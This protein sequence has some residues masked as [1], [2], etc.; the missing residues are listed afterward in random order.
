MARPMTD[1]P[2]IV[3]PDSALL[4]GELPTLDAEFAASHGPIFQIA[5]PSGVPLVFMVGPE[6][7]RFVLHTHR[8]HF[9]HALGWTPVLGNWAGQGLL[10]LAPPLHT[11]HRR[12]MNPAFTSAFMTTY[13][14]IMQRVVAR[15][16][17]DWAERNEVD[18]AVETREIAFDVAAAAL[19]GLHSGGPIEQL[20][21]LF[22]GLLH[23][24]DGSR[25]TPEEFEQR[26][27]AMSAQVDNLLLPII[28]AR[29][30]DETRPRDVLG[31][32]ATARDAEDKPLSDAQ[33]LAH[34]KILLIAGHE[35]TTTLAAWALYTLATHPEYRARVDAELAATATPAD[36]PISF[37][38]L[39]GMRF[40]DVFLKEVGRLY[41]PVFQVPRGVLHDFEFGGYSIPAGTRVR[42]GLAACHRLPTIWTRPDE[43]DPSRFEPPREEDKNHPYALVTFGGGPRVCIGMSFAQLEVKALV[44]HVLRHFH[45][46]PAPGPAPVLAGYWTAFMPTG[47]RVRV[48]RI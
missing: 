12:L 14:P 38:G 45:L 17:R 40:F 5:T 10:N 32:I 41:S 18:L 20:R 26:Q 21:A 1:L 3:Y 15:Q 11:E 37:E 19:T 25:E 2:S 13:L 44:A 30:T 42:L 24:F 34:V 33:I 36:A 16:T 48:K 43:F 35:T 4:S 29:R 28:A 23:G 39:R 46:E 7:N 31:L 9:S 8:E 27:A 22:Y 47:V 6:A